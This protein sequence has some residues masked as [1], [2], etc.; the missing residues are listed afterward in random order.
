M[1]HQQGLRVVTT[2]AAVGNFVAAWIKVMSVSPDSFYV[3]FIG[4]AM[5]AA[6]QLFILNVPARLAV[7]WFGKDEVSTACS[8]GVLGNQ[9]QLVQWFISHCLLATGLTFF[10]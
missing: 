2:L 6:A 4:Q 1:Q 5:A 7:V 8:L 9:V 3:S 10:K